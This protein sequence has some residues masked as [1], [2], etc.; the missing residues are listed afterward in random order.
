[1]TDYDDPEQPVPPLVGRESPADGQPADHKI[2]PEEP[3]KTVCISERK[4]EANRRNGA[5]GGV[6]TEEGK[7][8]S[9]RNALKHGLRAT[10]LLIEDE[11]TA[12]GQSFRSRAPPRSTC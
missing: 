9:R 4:L 3:G 5:K 6:K 10:T 12:E 2:R 7:R 1:M 11:T 8:R